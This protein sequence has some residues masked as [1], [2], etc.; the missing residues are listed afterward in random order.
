MVELIRI[1][2]LSFS[3]GKKAVLSK[4]NLSVEKGE[5]LGI[6]VPVGSGKSTLLFTMN[7]VIPHLLGGNF[8]GEVLSCGMDTRKTRVSELSK[9]VGIV[10]Q[11]PNSQIFSLRVW[12]EVAFALQ[13]RGM[14]AEEIEKRVMKYLKLFG[15]ESLKDQN[16]SNLSEGQKQKLTVASTLAMEPEVILLDE[17]SSSLDFAGA[18]KLYEILKQLNRQGRTIIV[19]EHDTDMLVGNVKRVVFLRDGRIELDGAPERVLSSP[20][21]ERYGLKIPCML[22]HMTKTAG[23]GE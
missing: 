23:A 19:V 13:N 11:D 12:D 2:G 8:E 4:L 17:P 14:P 5:F 15:L 6:I 7:G 21:I 20:R 3:Y 1:S 9:R 10:L 18:R 16:P 22:R